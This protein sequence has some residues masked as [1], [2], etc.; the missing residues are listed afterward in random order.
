GGLAFGVERDDLA[1]E[2]ER[3]L[4]PLRPG[5]KRGRNLGKLAGFFVAEARPEVNAGAARRD[6]SNRPNAVVLRFGDEIGIDER[7]VGERREHRAGNRRR[8]H[9]SIMMRRLQLSFGFEPVV[10]IAAV[11]AATLEIAVIGASPDVVF[12]DSDGTDVGRVRL[13]AIW[14]VDCA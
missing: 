13:S 4:E 7:H 1:V 6:L 3:L 9:A 14:T 12:S 8:G 5:A 10:E 2:D 11:A